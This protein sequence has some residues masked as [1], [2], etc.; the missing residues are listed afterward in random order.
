MPLNLQYNFNWNK[1]LMKVLYT[2]RK[3]SIF[4]Y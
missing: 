4:F 2:E 1:N 3:V